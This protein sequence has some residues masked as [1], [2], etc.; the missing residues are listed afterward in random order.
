MSFTSAAEYGEFHGITAATTP[1]GS[2][3]ITPLTAPAGSSGASQS[4]ARAA[5]RNAAA[6]RFNAAWPHPVNQRAAP[7]SAL[8]RSAISSARTAR[9]A[10]S[11]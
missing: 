7:P 9:A 1:I 3:R 4:K 2:H 5:R 10:S 6:C 11:R 8:A